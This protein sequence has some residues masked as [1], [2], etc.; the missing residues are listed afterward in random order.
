MKD[1]NKR[2]YIN[3]KQKPNKCAEFGKHEANV[4]SK[5]SVGAHGCFSWLF[6]F[7]IYVVLKLFQGMTIDGNMPGGI[8]AT[9]QNNVN[10]ITNYAFL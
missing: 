3:S 2:L 10:F 8:L 6:T 4:F 7:V 1:L 5:H 9:L